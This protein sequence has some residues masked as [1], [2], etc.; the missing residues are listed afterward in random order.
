MAT[1]IASGPRRSSSETWSPP[2]DARATPARGEAG[3]VST[4]IE[5]M[6]AETDER[7]E[8]RAPHENFKVY[9]DPAESADK[10]QTVDEALS[11]L[12]DLESRRNDPMRL[13]M[14]EAQRKNLIGADEE[15]VLAKT[16]E[17]A[18][19]EAVDVLAAWP[20]GIARLFEAVA[21]A[22]A[23]RTPVTSIV[24]G[25][26]EDTDTWPL[27]AEKGSDAIPAASDSQTHSELGVGGGADGEDSAGAS[28][29]AKVAS[30]HALVDSAGV[31]DSAHS[32]IRVFLHAL[33]LSR[34]FLLQLSDAALDAAA[35]G[36]APLPCSDA[37]HRRGPRP[38]GRRQS[39]ARPVDR[40]ALSVQRH[41]DGRPD[42]GGQYWPALRSGAWTRTL[43]TALGIGRPQHLPAAAGRRA[44]AFLGQARAARPGA[45][46]AAQIVVVV[47]M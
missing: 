20:V 43:K 42:P 3:H 33:S 21:M 12:D 27:A 47:G 5:D 7:F 23:G 46:A 44:R 18:S 15:V 13:Y 30:L 36:G 16:M 11:I 24:A 45:G 39:E 41:P 10:E 31:G 35:E 26:H 38:T 25:Q 37:T 9:V 1:G 28:L 17:T 29:F 19:R 22:R 2:A 8:Y 34:S 6:G 4:V 14:R 32:Q 40:Q